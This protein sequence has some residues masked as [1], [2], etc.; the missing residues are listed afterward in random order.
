MEEESQIYDYYPFRQMYLEMNGWALSD[1]LFFKLGVDHFTEFIA[2]KNTFAFTIPTQW[3]WKLIN[4]SSFTMYLESQQQTVNKLSPIDPPDV[5]QYISHYLSVSYSHMGRWIVTGFYD[6]ES[7]NKK[8]M[9]DP[10]TFEL[11]SELT[12]ISSTTN[13]WPSFD[14]TFFITSDT[15]I[16]L[17]YGSQKGG[18]VCAN[19]ICAEQPGFED[20]YKITFRSMF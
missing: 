9:R 14:L 2:G 1:R 10:D 19:G 7:Y 4:G 3:V 11:F 5:D 8:M 17:F 6:Y 20:G 18:L 15:Q 16:S 12:T 13:Q